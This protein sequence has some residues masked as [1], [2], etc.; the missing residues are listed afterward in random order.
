MAIFDVLFEF[1]DA[2]AITGDAQSEDVLDWGSGMEDL[3][4]GA[5][6]PIY[7]NVRVGSADFAGGTSLKTSLYSHTAATSIQSGTAVWE[8]PT[9]LQ[10]ALTAGAWI[11]QGV[12]LPNN[13]DENRYMGLYYDDTGAFSAGSIDAWLS[14]GTQSTHN[15]QVAASNI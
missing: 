12:V 2:Q 14:S 11:A 13:C 4:M 7:L 1:S 8:S 15:T 6:T 10:A 9:I 3:E 5:G